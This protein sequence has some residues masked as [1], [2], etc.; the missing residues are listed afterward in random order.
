[1]KFWEILKEENVGKKYKDN[2]NNKIWEIKK[3]KTFINLVDEFNTDIT[4]TFDSWD[5]IILDFEEVVD[6]SKVA[7]QILRTSMMQYEKPYKEG[8]DE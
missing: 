7:L 5:L 2:L 4:R 3:Y 8:V 1:M 6:W